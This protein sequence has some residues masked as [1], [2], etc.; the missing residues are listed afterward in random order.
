MSRSR[1]RA[2]LGNLCQ[3]Y[4]VSDGNEVP[5]ADHHAKALNAS[6]VS[7]NRLAT[8]PGHGSRSRLEHHDA[9]PRGARRVPAE[10]IDGRTTRATPGSL[11]LPDQCR[12]VP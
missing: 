10:P 4:G 3:G 11:G 5:F 9:A 12:K 2:T 1:N 8:Q 6:S 7:A